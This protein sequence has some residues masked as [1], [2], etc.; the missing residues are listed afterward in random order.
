MRVVAVVGVMMM[1]GAAA[2]VAAGSHRSLGPRMERTP[3]YV[4]DYCKKSRRLPLACAHLQPKMSQPSPH[5]EANLCLV[6][7]SGCA[8]L[9]WD[10]LSLADAGNGNRP[11]IWSHVV[12]QA[13]NRTRTSALYIGSFTWGGKCGTVILA[14][15]FP[16]GGEQ[17]GHLIFR[18]REHQTDFALGLHGWSYFRKCLDADRG[19]RPRF[20]HMASL[21]PRRISQTLTG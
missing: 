6:G 8:G 1:L 21:M 9:T 10:E 17:G 16:N 11:P 20:G 13:G 5:W 18:W 14:P 12:V 7:H 3:A 2:A 15:D 19:L 4:L